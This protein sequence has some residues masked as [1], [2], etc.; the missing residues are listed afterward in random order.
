MGTAK[1]SYMAKKNAGNN[2]FF[3]ILH[4]IMVDKSDELYAEHIDNPTFEGVYTTVGIEKALGKC[5]GLKFLTDLAD[6]QCDC[7]RITDI[8]HHYWFLMR[9]L[10]K[11]FKGIDW[12]LNG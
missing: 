7:S 6:C 11:T 10:P 2:L 12:K 3:L 8:R 1:K 9:K 4:N 5:L